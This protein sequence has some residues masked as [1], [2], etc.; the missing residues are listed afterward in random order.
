M[1]RRI[2]VPIAKFSVA[3]VLL[4]FALLLGGCRDNRQRAAEELLARADRLY[5]ERQYEEA[6]RTIDTL[7]RS[8]PAAVGIRR[9]ALVLQQNIELKRTQAELIVLDSALQVV[10]TDYERQRQAVETA[11]AE[12]RATAE[13]LTALTKARLYRDSLQARFD[14][15]CAK[16]RLIHKKQKER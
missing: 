4:L 5:T 3:G 10:K 7:R 1:N 11:K 6:L 14:A 9:D 8:Y 2:F 16:V 15:L 13:D 12:L